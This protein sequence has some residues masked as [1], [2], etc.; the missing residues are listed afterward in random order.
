M[1]ELKTALKYYTWAE[2]ERCSGIISGHSTN[3]ADLG[4][5]RNTWAQIRVHMG[6][7]RVARRGKVVYRAYIYV[8]VM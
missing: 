5:M 2:R 7:A 3:D 6:I 8:V 1:Y 4:R